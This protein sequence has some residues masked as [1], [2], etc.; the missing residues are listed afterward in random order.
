MNKKS[1]ITFFFGKKSIIQLVQ[2]IMSLLS[3]KKSIESI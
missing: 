1:K 3:Y 2:I